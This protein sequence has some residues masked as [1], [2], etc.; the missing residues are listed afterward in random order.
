MCGCVCVRIRFGRGGFDR[1]VVVGV[2]RLPHTKGLPRGHQN[3]VVR[4]VGRRALVA[5]VGVGVVVVVTVHFSRV[6]AAQT[7]GNNYGG[8][9]H[10]RA[11]LQWVALLFYQQ[12]R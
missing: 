4:L 12:K 1:L 3:G 11:Y 9:P 7:T 6:Y 2:K 5:F 8:K 10:H